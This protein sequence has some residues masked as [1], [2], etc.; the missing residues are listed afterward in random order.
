MGYP[1][2]I[3]KD[4]L[5]VGRRFAA[6]YYHDCS[7]RF[8]GHTTRAQP[9]GFELETNGFQFY[10]IANLDKTSLIYPVTMLYS[11]NY[12]IVRKCSNEQRMI[13]LST[14][15]FRSPADNLTHCTETKQLRP[16]NNRKCRFDNGFNVVQNRRP[17]SLSGGTSNG[18]TP[19]SHRTFSSSGRRPVPKNNPIFPVRP[20]L[21]RPPGLTGP[22]LT[23]ACQSGCLQS[24]VVAFPS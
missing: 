22:R 10:A 20:G 7:G 9:V 17:C 16:L 5:T 12:N 14:S 4:S 3:L 18:T 1:W 21:I 6:V 2:Y 19:S 24:T 8:P 15:L 11:S 23:S 13:A